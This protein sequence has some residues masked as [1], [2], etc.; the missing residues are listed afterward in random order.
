M[1][2]IS[3][4]LILFLAPTAL[5]AGPADVA[6]ANQSLWPTA[7]KDRAGYDRA[8]RAEILVFLKILK[9]S[10][11]GEATPDSLGIKKVNAESLAKWRARSAD[12]WL[13]AYID[14]SKDCGGK[15]GFGCGF[16]GSTFDE[17]SAFSS[18]FVAGLEPT[19]KPWLE[20][21]E[22]FYRIYA[23][24]QMRLAA[25]FPNPTSEIL[26][27]DDA[28]VFGDR[29]RDGEFLLTLDDGPTPSGGDTEKYAQLLRNEGISA[30][31]FSLGQAL[32]TRI[33]KSSQEAVAKMYDK[34][35]LASHGF[36]HKSHQ[37]WKEWSESLSKTKTQIKRAVPGDSIAF[38][39]PY[40]QRSR[41]LITE[42]QKSFNAPVMLWN[43]DSQDWHSKID[44]SQVGDR[45][46]KL[47]LLWRKGIVLFHDVH[48]K[49]LAAL[50][51]LIRLAKSAE[52][53]WVDCHVFQPEIATAAP[54]KSVE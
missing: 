47:M 30:F 29:F 33:D 32:Q 39:P 49:A 5:G 53:K 21:S 31:F 7:I 10:T 48:S 22:A 34:Q 2:I 26:S 27:L 14:A 45:V 25:L 8:S 28:E 6:K 51:G 44:A 42:Q 18:A 15:P 35:C 1:K 17:L 24:E 16:K 54:T 46:Q 50:P 23:K 13:R 12:F 41:E 52:L 43:I 3:A 4:L 20:M 36:E 40:G 38:R 11:A 19:Y 9:E 37:K